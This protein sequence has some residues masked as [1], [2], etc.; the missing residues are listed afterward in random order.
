MCEREIE[1]YVVCHRVFNCV[2]VWERDLNNGCV[3]GEERE[4]DRERERER[5]WVCV[6]VL[7]VCVSHLNIRD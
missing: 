3:R 1:R 4:R 2:C 6:S 7:C 5:K